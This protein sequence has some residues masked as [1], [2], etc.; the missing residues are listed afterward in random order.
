M[1]NSYVWLS[2]LIGTIVAGLF[3]YLIAI[4]KTSGRIN[5]TEATKLWEEA[6]DIREVYRHEIA[7]LRSEVSVLKKQNRELNAEVASLQNQLDE[8][9]R[10]SARLQ[11]RVEELE[12]AS[13]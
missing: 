4:R 8:C 10:R 5:T 6:A 12:D 7:E 3:T 9:A 11:I 13:V 1:A 2:P